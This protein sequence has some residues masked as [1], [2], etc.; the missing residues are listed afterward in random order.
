MLIC[1]MALRKFSTSLLESYLGNHTYAPTSMGGQR[2]SGSGA[3]EKVRLG[4][5][6]VKTSNVLQHRTPCQK[7]FLFLDHL[8][9]RKK[10]DFTEEKTSRK[11]RSAFR[12]FH[13]F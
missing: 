1:N 12:G 9:N 8:H 10:F 4:P 13:D 3:V 2:R 6:P 7:R 5:A 11:Y